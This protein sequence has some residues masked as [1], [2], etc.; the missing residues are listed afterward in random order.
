MNSASG[1]GQQGLAHAGGPGEDE[2]AGGALGVFQ[3]AAAAAHR[4]RHRPDRLVLA[5]H[6][7]VQLLLHAHQARRILGAQPRQ[8]HAGDLGDHLGNHVLVHHAVGLARFLPP[9]VRD[10]LLFL[11][12]LVGL[13]PQ[14]GGL[15]EILVGDRL[16]L[17]LVEL[18]DLLVDV[19]QVGRAGHRLQV[20]PGPGLVDHVDGLIGQ[21]TAGNVAIRHFHGR[22]NGVVGDPHVMVLLVAIAEPLEDVDR[23]V[24]GGGLDHHHLEAAIERAVFLDVLAIL[25]QG[26]GADA[27]DF[28]AAEGGLEHVAGVD[29]PFGPAG[30]HQGVQLVDE[31]DGVLGAADLVHHGLDPLFELSAVLR[32]GDH[33]GQVEHHDAAIQQQLGDVP[34]DY[35]LGESLDD[36][37]LAHAGLAQ[38]HRV[39]FRPPAEDLHGPLDFLLAADDRVELALAGQFGQIAAEAVQGGRLRLAGPR[40]LAGGSA[41]QTAGP[42]GTFRAF[43][44]MAQQVQDLFADLFQLQAEVHQHLGGHPLLL[45]QQSEQDVFGAH[46]VVIEDAGFLHRVFD[47]LLGPGRLRQLAH[48]HHVGPALHQLLDLQT[49]LAQIDVEV[50]QHVGGHPAPLFDQAQEDV[51]GADIFVIEPLGL[52][53]GQLHDLPGAVSKS[54][55]HGCSPQRFPLWA[56]IFSSRGRGLFRFRLRQQI[57]LALD[58]PMPFAGAFQTHQRVKLPPGVVEPARVPQQ[59]RQHQP[60]VHVAKV[61]PQQAFQHVLRLVIIAF[62]ITVQRLGKTVRGRFWPAGGRPLPAIPGGPSGRGEP[63]QSESGPQSAT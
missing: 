57:P 60:G 49:D 47:D 17:L 37:R 61:S 39:V 8:R 21:A 28:A 12:Q 10:S 5:D 26:R 16:F 9:L 24:F 1:L 32:A 7:L 62:Q 27:L 50:L 45:A 11:L 30:A 23:L 41:G 59:R 54:L 6:A 34:L 29:G 25:V 19:F 63:K 42:L 4:L 51:L 56:R 52:L 38:Q 18:L 55:V 53:V 35:P 58:F 43:H 13:V 3:A 20:H 15:F 31:Q 33:H 44:A 2:A 36:G 14:R 46:V 22:L 40:R 48:G